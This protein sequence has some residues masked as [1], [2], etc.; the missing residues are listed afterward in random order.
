M[1]TPPISK[2][3]VVVD[4]TTRVIVECEPD[5]YDR[6]D[7]KE[8]LTMVGYFAGRD[9]CGPVA[10]AVRVTIAS[11][12]PRASVMARSWGKQMVS[13]DVTFKEGDS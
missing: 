6:H 10:N 11:A 12:Y 1:K 3:R 4:V 7:A 5:E 2:V 13:A 9:V 8:A